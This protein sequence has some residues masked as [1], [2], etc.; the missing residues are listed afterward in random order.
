MA[1]LL[2]DGYSFVHKFLNLCNDG[3]KT[4]LNLECRAG[5]AFINLRRDLDVAQ[6]G[7]IDINILLSPKV[8]GS[9][10]IAHG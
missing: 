4:N 3:E 10:T 1:A 9:I 2:Q 7:N 8:R 6:T 5:K